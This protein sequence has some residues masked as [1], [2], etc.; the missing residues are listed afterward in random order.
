MK[1]KLITWCKIGRIYFKGRGENLF[2]FKKSYKFCSSISKTKHVWF[3]CWKHSKALT[4]LNSSAFSWLN[5]DNIDTSIC[6]WRAYEGWFFKIFIATMSFVPFFQHLTTC[7]NVPRPRN[8]ST[9]KLRRKKV[10]YFVVKNVKR[11]Y[12][13]INNYSLILVFQIWIW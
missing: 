12:I 1:K 10:S 11:L 6:P 8:S 3:L 5:R 4:K 9:W 2:C 7:P 13:Y